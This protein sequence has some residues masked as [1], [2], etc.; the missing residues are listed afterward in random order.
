MVRGSCLS[1]N[2]N[3]EIGIDGKTFY[4]SHMNREMKSLLLYAL[5]TTFFAL[6]FS[7]W[8]GIGDFSTWQALGIRAGILF[9]VLLILGR[10]FKI[11]RPKEGSSQREA[12]QPE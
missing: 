6:L 7:Y 12:E 1:S 8:W 4:L 10:V 11:G 2:R 5:L 3:P 9:V